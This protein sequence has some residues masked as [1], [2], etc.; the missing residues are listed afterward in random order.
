MERLIELY[1][2]DYIQANVYSETGVL[3]DSYLSSSPERVEF[4]FNTSEAAYIILD[5]ANHTAYVIDNLT[6]Y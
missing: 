6:F 3:I 2:V 1:E 4:N 5:D